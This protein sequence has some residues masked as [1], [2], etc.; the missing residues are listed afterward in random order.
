[1]TERQLGHVLFRLLGLWLAV[2]TVRALGD[3]YFK[4][5]ELAAPRT[6]A[7]AWVLLGP[8][9]LYLATALVIWSWAPSLAKL[10][11]SDAPPGAQ[12]TAPP[13]W[14]IYRAVVAAFGLYLVASALP[15]IVSWLAYWL[16]TD[17]GTPERDE[18]VGVHGKA[19]GVSLLAQCLV[20]TL[21]YIGPRKM[22]S[23]ARSEFR[24]RLKE[25]EGS[26]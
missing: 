8:F 14:S 25:E 2:E 16:Q 5:H 18:L 19:Q 24:N 20:G 10:T 13:V 1:M 22:L 15:T 11:F 7:E 3:V 12:G 4:W 26:S 21:L 17:P 9:A 6:T 23:L